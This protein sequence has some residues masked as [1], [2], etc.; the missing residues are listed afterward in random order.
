MSLAMTYPTP[1]PA[2]SRLADT[3]DILSHI[4]SFLPQSTLFNVLQVSKTFFHASVPHLYHTL[5]I[6]PGGRN[7][8]AGSRRLD[9]LTLDQKPTFNQTDP[10]NEI[11]KNSLSKYIKRVDVYIHEINECP[12]V[13]QYIE[14]LPN[15]EI[16][17]LAKGKR[18]TNI[19]TS[20]E[21]RERICSNEKC[22][23]V[24]KVCTNAE[25]V[26]VREL[27]F[28]SIMKFDKLEKVVLKLRPCELPFYR[29][30]GMSK[31]RKS[32]Y[33]DDP[34]GDGGSQREE[35]HDYSNI[36]FRSFHHL[37][38]SVKQLDL[39]W[40]DERH[41]YRID[42]Y[43]ASFRGFGHWFGRA[44]DGGG[45]RTMKNCNYCDQM[46]CIRYSPH[47]GIQLPIMFKVL[48]RQTNIRQI[49][50][51]N[52]ERVGGGEWQWK[53]YEVGYEDL[54]DQ[55]KDGFKIGRTERERAKDTIDC[56]DHDQEEGMVKFH[57]GLEYYSTHSQDNNEIDREEMKYW[58]VRFD[59]PD[60][61]R[62]LRKRVIEEMEK[63]S[64]N[65]T[66]VKIDFWSEDSCVDWLIERHN[67][68]RAEDERKNKI[69]MIEEEDESD[70]EGE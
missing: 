25:K 52:F 69:E 68:Q 1:S 8:F 24:T 27:D 31:Y 9:N 15:L 23:F 38:P 30:E 5:T 45:V 58:K 56:S 34:D 67:A 39:V 47:V 3:S 48:G 17:H 14:P 62:E 61:L 49:N 35:D 33:Q 55:L 32:L 13:K 40:W 57:S 66:D 51:W 41:Q 18:P 6:A 7:I 16:L 64:W 12:F 70:V 46:G 50:V 20:D 21:D 2:S 11:N 37:P 59:P 36:W 19:S 53:D 63:K 26:I 10:S 4:F 29:G 44:G 28:R 42:S 22:Q 65:T 43:E 54:K 60:K